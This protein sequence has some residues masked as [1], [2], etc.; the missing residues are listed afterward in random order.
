MNQVAF[1]K[2]LEHL[3]IRLCAKQ[4][5]QFVLYHKHLQ[6][7]AQRVRLVSRNDRSRI[8]ERHFLDSLTAVPL[9]G[10]QPSRMLDLGSG[11]GFPG[12]PIKI[13]I[14]RLD[15]VLLE[16]ARMK[17]LFLRSLIEK[18]EVGGV[19]CVR[20]R[21]EDRD[22]ISK[23]Q[24]R[25]DIVVSRAVGPLRQLCVWIRP[26]LNVGGRILVFKGPDGVRELEAKLYS[27]W[28]IVAHPVDVPFGNQ[29]RYLMDVRLK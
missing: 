4:T 5:N 29:N 15:V 16:P 9:I 22:F 27:E 25:F 14:P 11:A 12:M 13:V 10:T 3:R 21:V 28:N 1:S 2:A 7:W 6:E 19:I 24:G 23:F 18:L 26:L 20:E 17:A 8:W